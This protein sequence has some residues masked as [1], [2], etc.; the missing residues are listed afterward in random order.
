LCWWV[1]HKVLKKVVRPRSMT[2]CSTKSFTF[3]HCSIINKLVANYFLVEF[4]SIRLV[5]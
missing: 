1:L 2:I 4:W 3:Y 5:S